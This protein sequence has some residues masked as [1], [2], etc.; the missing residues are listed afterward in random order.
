[1]HFPPFFCMINHAEGRC[2][3]ER[4]AMLKEKW[5]IILLA[6][7]CLTVGL[8]YA[9]DQPTNTELHI[10]H[11]GETE[12]SPA[13]PAVPETA[14]SPFPVNINEADAAVLDLLPGIGP[15]KAEAI[16]ND[17]AERGLFLAPEE[18]MRVRGI[19]EGTFAK[20]KDFITVGSAGAPEEP[21]TVRDA[22]TEAAPLRKPGDAPVMI[23]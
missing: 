2:G 22:E 15:V 19:K 9:L 7:L 11:A 21:P 18:I 10:L 12:V 20:L 3:A 4:N 6:V 8:F 17:R 16:V 13:D 1:M 14:V 5:P 23:R